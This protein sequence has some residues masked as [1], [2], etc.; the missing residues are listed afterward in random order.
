MP[1]QNSYSEILIPKVKVLGDE[2]FGRWLVHEGRALLNGISAFMKETT[3]RSL[4]RVRM[5]G[6]RQSMKQEVGPH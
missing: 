3:E 1:L 6:K 5:Q 2:A 4:S